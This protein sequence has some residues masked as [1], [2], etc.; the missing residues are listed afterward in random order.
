[1]NKKRDLTRFVEVKG[2]KRFPEVGQCI[3]CG[4][5]EN[6][7]DEHVVPF[8]LGGRLVLPKSSCNTCSAITSSFEKKVL[9]GF[10]YEARVTGKYP[11]RR[12]KDRP[13][14]LCINL[15]TGEKFNN[16]HLPI[17]ESPGLLQLPV[18]EPPGFLVGREATRG[19]KICG[20]ETISFGRNLIDVLREHNVNSIRQTTNLDV[21]S[22][23]RMLAKIGY[24]FAV[25]INGL[26]PLK[27]VPVLPLILGNSDDGNVWV[28]SARYQTESE[29]K[30]AIHALTTYEH[31][32]NDCQMLISRVKLFASSGTTGYEVIV[33]AK[34]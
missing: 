9:R 21:T 18:L 29:L 24:S 30:G 11:T 32:M 31:F 17:S 20:I 1:M 23:A 2:T 15:G 14:E 12:P 10:M 26:L 3:Y 13:S 27:N 19:V 4:A 5:K 33:Y 7:S 22:F 16:F 8:A 6:L 34:L 25:G 28:G